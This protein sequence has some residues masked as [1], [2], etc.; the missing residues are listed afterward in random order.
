MELERKKKS[1]DLGADRE[2]YWL[3]RVTKQSTE[4]MSARYSRDGKLKVG[5]GD[6]KKK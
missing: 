4:R 1:F 6:K 2:M 3:A 5:K